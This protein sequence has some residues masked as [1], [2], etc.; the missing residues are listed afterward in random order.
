MS[1]VSPPPC[2]GAVVHPSVFPCCHWP[3][4]VDWFG[5]GVRATAEVRGLVTG[6]SPEWP[7]LCAAGTSDLQRLA[8]LQ[9]YTQ[10]CLNG[11]TKT[12][13][14]VCIS[15]FHNSNVPFDMCVYLSLPTDVAETVYSVGAKD[16]RGWASLFHMYNISLSEAQKNQI[17]FAL[18]CSTDPNK[19]KRW[20]VSP[21]SFS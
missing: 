9:L 8:P 14:I 4:N 1:W 6:L 16:D 15:E 2:F 12:V 13:A 17:M 21:S 19:L 5:L 10:V 7:C 18:T 3:A 20:I 11:D